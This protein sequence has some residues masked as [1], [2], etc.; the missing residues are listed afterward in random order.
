MQHGS[1][2]TSMGGGVEYR[3]G[4][5]DILRQGEVVALEKMLRL[6]PENV[7]GE[8]PIQEHREIERRLR[9]AYGEARRESMQ[10]RRKNIKKISELRGARIEAAKIECRLKSIGVSYGDPLREELKRYRDA[11]I[12]DANLD[13]ETAVIMENSRNKDRLRELTLTYKKGLSEAKE[14]TKRVVA[15]LVREFSVQPDES[16]KDRNKRIRSE[17]NPKLLDPRKDDDMLANVVSWKYMSYIKRKQRA[18]DIALR[19]R[20]KY[21]IDEASVKEFCDESFTMLDAKTF[22]WWNKQRLKGNSP[23][24]TRRYALLNC[25]V[26]VESLGCAGDLAPYQWLSIDVEHREYGVKAM[27]EF[28]GYEEWEPL[29]TRT[30]RRGNT[31]RIYVRSGVEL[32]TR[33]L[34]TIEKVVDRFGTDG[35]DGAA[36]SAAGEL[37]IEKLG[38]DII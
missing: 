20:N 16:S 2:N 23:L 12:E 25:M 13:Y 24:F 36:D 27:L 8:N 10:Q 33:D 7:I 30:T 11:E 26:S 34:Q 15:E 35:T 28:F 32:T 19:S 38:E 3:L 17:V 4:R 21:S 14:E 18:R 37:D 29:T 6:V 31:E 5:L 1:D 9:E 22:R